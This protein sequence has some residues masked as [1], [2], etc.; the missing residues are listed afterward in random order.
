MPILLSVG[1][2]SPLGNGNTAIKVGVRMGTLHPYSYPPSR[3]NHWGRPHPL[4]GRF[5][6]LI[7]DRAALDELS[8]IPRIVCR[9]ETLVPVLLYSVVDNPVE[10]LWITCGSCGKFKWALTLS[11]RLE[12][13]FSSPTYAVFPVFAFPLSLAL[14]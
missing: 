4:Q 9:M 1:D 10:N 14:V 13:Q 2:T 11:I 12:S 8:E 3:C 7:N 6:P 5:V